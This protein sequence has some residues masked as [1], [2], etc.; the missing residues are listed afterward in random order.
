MIGLRLD[1]RFYRVLMRRLLWQGSHAFLRLALCNGF[2]L[3]C[4]MPLKRH[5]NLQA[6][7]P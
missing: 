4:S 6:K 7:I 5:S 1:Y 3:V 2:A